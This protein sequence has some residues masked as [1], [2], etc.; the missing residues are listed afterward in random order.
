VLLL[1]IPKV[2]TVLGKY[3]TDYINDDFGTHINIGRLGLQFNGDVELK[4][5][6]IEDY[7]KDTLIAIDELNTS[8][9]NYHN[10]INGT[11]DFGDID[12]IN[13]VFNVKTYKGGTDSNLDIFVDK[14]ESDN[15]RKEKSTFLMSSSDVTLYNGI[16]RFIDENKEIPKLLE[17]NDLNI[18]ATNFVI[19]GSEVRTRINTLSLRDTRGVYV[20][21]MVTDFE[22]T[23]NHMLFNN[24]SITT[25][26]SNLSGNLRFDYDRE[27][28][29]Y[30]TDK[31]LITAD[32]KDSEIYLNDL[33]IFYNEFGTNQKAKIDVDLS[34]TLNDL[35]AKKPK[36]KCQRK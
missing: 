36:T 24:L 6:F 8:I 1:S 20:K 33:N 12:I 23:L 19:A 14:F 7:K 26:Q 2:Q 16:F 15:P 9:L 3:V 29:K 18:N 13:L 35:T 34:G 30:F 22:Y 32:F 11:L 31:V 17:F 27:D 4:D 28:F 21:N 25:K 10:L 5:I